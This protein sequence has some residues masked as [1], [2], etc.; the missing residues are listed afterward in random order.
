MALK[1]QPPAPLT[2][3]RQL[4]KVAAI[5]QV[6]TDITLGNYVCTRNVGV[7]EGEKFA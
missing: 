1:R 6:P 7:T 2:Y 5:S 4:T 3:S